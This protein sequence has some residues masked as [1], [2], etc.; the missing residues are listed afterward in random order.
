MLIKLI[1]AIKAKEE[2][3][4]NLLDAL[5]W[6]RLSWDN[7]PPQTIANCFRHCGFVVPEDTTNTATSQT[8]IPET[9]DGNSLL[10]R[11][12][13]SRFELPDDVTFENFSTAD[14]EVLTTVALSVEDIALIIQKEDTYKADDET[15]DSPIPLPPPAAKEANSSLSILK[16]YFESRDQPIGESCLPLVASLEKAVAN[17]I[18]HACMCTKKITDFM[19]FV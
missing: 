15:D 14:S 7:V 19:N 3:S 17:D 13:M 1:A 18:S 11:L 6:L 12:S 2:F 5:Y 16:R 9:A 10:A 8:D 4:P